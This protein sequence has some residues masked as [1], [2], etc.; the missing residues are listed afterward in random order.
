MTQDCSRPLTRAALNSSIALAGLILLA[1]PV[2]AQTPVPRGPYLQM[3]TPTSIVVKWRTTEPSDSRVRFGPAPGQLV[4]IVDDP[5]INTDHEVALS[6][7][8]PDTV[9]YYSY[10]ST[11]AIIG[12]DDAEHYFRTAPPTGS[13]GPVRIWAIGDSG[14]ANE[15]IQTVRDAYTAYTGSVGTDV[16][17]MLGDN[18]YLI[19]TDE[20]YQAA[21]FEIFPQMLRTTVLWPTFGNHE[22]PASSSP[23]ESGPY[24][25]IFSLPRAGEAGGVASGTEAY[26]SFDYGNVH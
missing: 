24:Y 2:R 11:T 26:Y 8:S 20:Q 7:L 5:G 4:N 14:L 23:D 22:R 10:G 16:W 3:G 6:G 19:G 12:G 25:D 21:V 1:L 17:L 15:N 13:Q 18:A 9:Y